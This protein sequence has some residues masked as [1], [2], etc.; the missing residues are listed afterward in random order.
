MSGITRE[1]L[2][3]ATSTHFPREIYG[4]ITQYMAPRAAHHYIRRGPSIVWFDSCYWSDITAPIYYWWHQKGEDICIA[5]GKPEGIAIGSIATRDERNFLDEINDKFKPSPYPTGI[6]EVDIANTSCSDFGCYSFIEF[7]SIS[8][9]NVMLGESDILCR[10]ILR[11]TERDE[12]YDDSCQLR[13]MFQRRIVARGYDKYFMFIWI[14]T[15][16]RVSALSSESWTQSDPLLFRYIVGFSTAGD[17]AIICDFIIVNYTSLESD[18][19]P[20]K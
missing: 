3:T 9:L 2:I 14:G 8:E 19:D 11:H 1:Q 5:Y 13:D 7:L 12:L 17:M 18:G 10:W 4:I 15:R 6:V 20:Y 16:R